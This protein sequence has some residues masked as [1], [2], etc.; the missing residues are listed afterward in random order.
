MHYGSVIIIAIFV[1]N[2]NSLIKIFACKIRKINYRSLPM[3]RMLRE[4]IKASTAE[5]FTVFFI[6][7]LPK[8]KFC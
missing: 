3:L 7:T 4:I 1:L 5:I 8:N 2:P 6:L